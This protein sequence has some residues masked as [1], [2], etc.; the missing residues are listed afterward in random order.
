MGEGHGP[1]GVVPLVY[2]VRWRRLVLTANGFIRAA[3]DRV[4]HA[5]G[6]G[7]GW[8]QGVVTGGQLGA[9]GLGDATATEGGDAT[10]VAAR[11]DG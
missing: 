4:W 5:G 3:G 1:A 10:A 6:G 11:E 9:R 2:A 8:G 7:G